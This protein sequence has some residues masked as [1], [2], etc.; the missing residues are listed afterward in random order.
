MAKQLLTERDC[1]FPFRPIGKPVIAESRDNNGNVVAVTRATGVFQNWLRE[2][3][4]GRIYPKTI[5]DR[6]LKEESDFMKRVNNREVLGVIE[7]PEDGQTNLR[8][9][10]HVV[11][12]VRYATPDEIAN[13]GGS[14]VEG[15]ILGTYETL[16]IGDGVYLSGLHSANIGFGISSRGQ[17]NVTIKNGKKIVEDDFDLETWDVVC[18]PS[19]KHARPRAIIESHSPLREGDS[20]PLREGDAM[21]GYDLPVDTDEDL[22]DALSMM[23]FESDDEVTFHKEGNDHKITCTVVVPYLMSAAHGKQAYTVKCPDVSREFNSPGEVWQFII[24]K[25]SIFERFNPGLLFK[26]RALARH[27]KDGKPKAKDLKVI[28]ESTPQISHPMTKYDELRSLKG[29]IIRLLQTETKKL[30]ASDKAAILEEITTCRIKIDG[31][32]SEDK[33]L[34][35][36][37]QK[38][39]KR[40]QEF[41]DVVDSPDAPMA[42]EAPMVDD[43]VESPDVDSPLP[44]E[45]KDVISKAAEML[46]DLGGDSEEAQ[47]TAEE[48][49][50]LCTSDGGECG[51]DDEE[52]DFVDNIP[53][54]ESK[55]KA[56]GFIKRHRTLEAIHKATLVSAARLLEKVREGRAKRISESTV[57]GKSLREYKEAATELA[58]MY[59]TDMIALS[60]K[61][62]ETTKPKFFAE[63]ADKLKGFRTYKKFTEAVSK[64]GAL[65][66]TPARVAESRGGEKKVRLQ[67]AKAPKKLAESVHP[68]LTLVM[69]NRRK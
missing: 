55:I 37:G 44:E 54:A 31:I 65:D 26:S 68:A 10:S 8:L 29:G 58:E 6:L 56:I 1:P 30:K 4:N 63:N 5:W 61:L 2:N 3:S 45:A 21:P 20:S 25:D 60:L 48:L 52:T 59:N 36:E 27:R 53:V 15:D 17:G 43:D 64:A 22:I 9:V 38:L 46:K 18:N 62:L 7:H 23:G 47:Q 69:R 32:I 50:A 42:P 14:I 28:S 11:T 24:S 35:T 39:L 40:L 33:S 41:E 67:E 57:R 51:G 49:E 16:P 12:E 13:S 34:V 66:K 19:V